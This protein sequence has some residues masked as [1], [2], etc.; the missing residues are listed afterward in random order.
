MHYHKLVLDSGHPVSPQTQCL[1]LNTDEFWR[2]WLYV[3][4]NEICSA[5][6]SQRNHRCQLTT[7]N[8]KYL[9]SPNSMLTGS[10]PLRNLIHSLSLPSDII[11]CSVSYG[12]FLFSNPQV[13]MNN[14]VH[15]YQYRQITKQA[16]THYFVS[17]H[18]R[19]L[20][21]SVGHLGF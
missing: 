13:L 15:F 3:L 1:V 19:M 5:V 20:L 7:T 16:E 12:L 8:T 2:F 18:R 14:C 17:F 11:F 21:F 10:R 6:S 4:S 9:S